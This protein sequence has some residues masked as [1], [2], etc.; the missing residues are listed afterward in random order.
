M[1]VR[2]LTDVKKLSGEQTRV[3]RLAIV[4]GEPLAIS[5]ATLVEIAMLFGPARGRLRV[6]A[7]VL[8][9]DLETGA[10]F[11]IVPIDIVVAAEV[12]ALGD[13]LRDPSDRVIV[14]TARVHHLRLV[15]SDQRIIASKLASTVE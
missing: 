9:A 11:Q 13:A 7:E 8:F 1:V 6:S 5:A 10:G 4:R 2:W 3:L 12:A 14:A 15:T